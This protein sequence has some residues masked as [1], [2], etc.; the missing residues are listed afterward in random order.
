MGY[1]KNFISLISI[2]GTKKS[3][4]ILLVFLMLVSILIDILSLGLIIPY[5]SGILNLQDS[6]SSFYFFDISFLK[7]YSQ[8]NLIFFLTISLIIIFFIKAIFSIFIRWMIS[9]FSFKQFAILQVKV[10]NVYQNMNYEDHIS[11]SNSEYIRN[12]RELCGE[13]LTNIELTLKSL[14]E[15]IVL[16]VIVLFLGF[17]NYKILFLFFFT[18]LPIFII[19]EIFLKKVNIKFGEK[20]IEAMGKMY[21]NID[22]SM[23]G[24]KEI[25]VLQKESFFKKNLEKFANIVYETQK[26]S[27]LITDSPRYVFEFLI[28]L[29]SL[30]LIL[31]SSKN[32]DLNNYIPIVS[33]Y[34]LAAIRLLPSITFLA[35]SLSRVA[36]G[37]SAVSTIVG[38]LTK[39]EDKDNNKKQVFTEEFKNL[40]MQNIDFFYK[41]TG[42][43][44]LENVDFELKKN[45]C[46]GIMGKSGEGKTTLIDIMLGLLK[47]Q[48]GEIIING[49]LIDNYGSN[50]FDSIAYVPQEPVILDEKIST[51]ISLE[52]DEKKIDFEKLKFAINQANFEEV[53]KNLPKKIETIVGA[54]GIRLSGGQ[55]KRLALSRAFYHGKK[56][57]IIDEATSALDFETESNIAEEI[58]NL[59]GK[60]TIV[61]ISHNENILKYCNR[62]YTIKDK[63]IKSVDIFK[64]VEI[65]LTTSLIIAF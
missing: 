27:V 52:I 51:N 33:M 40:K 38:D 7:K 6:S 60:T 65:K 48:K 61:I 23:R 35:S 17:V 11:R 16:L 46:I 25:K 24:H 41:N 10:L 18:I 39:L 55:N 8:Q 12:I 13:C 49:K 59:K 19:Y 30:S 21:N 57:I 28:V 31:I 56:I 45:D 1:L 43:S 36:Y 15:I 26:K 58:K 4:L 37:H 22:V 3:Y 44:I 54:N 42:A 20:K 63:S 29:V 53:V 47:P 64:L 34:C 2:I 32:F 5:V 14:S 62:I 9:I 50:F